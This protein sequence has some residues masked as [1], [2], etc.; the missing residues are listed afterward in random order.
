VEALEAFELLVVGLE[1][2]VLQLEL[3]VPALALMARDVW[4]E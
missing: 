4:L 1:L 2:V 3:G